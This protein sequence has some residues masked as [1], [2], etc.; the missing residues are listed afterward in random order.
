MDS[1]FNGRMAAFRWLKAQDAA[2]RTIIPGR[3]LARGFEFEG[4]RIT[5]KGQ[6]GIWFPQGWEM[7]VSITTRKDGPYP[8]DS[9]SPDGV[10]TYA[11]RG[12]D[13][14]HH[15]NR[16]LRRACETRTPLIYFTEIRDSL[17][18]AVWPMIIVNDDPN[19]RCV[20]AMIEPAY[21]GLKPAARLD[22]D[23]LSP[24]DVRRY[25]TVQARQR[26]HQTAFRDLV[27]HAYD[28]HCAI[29]RLHHPELLDAAHITPDSESEGLPIVN[30]G[31]SLCKIHHAA[32][33]QQFI[34]IDPDYRV[35]VRR[36]LLEEKDGPMLRHGLQELEGGMLFLPARRRDVPDPDRLDERFRLFLSA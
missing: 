34:G 11:Y 1:E 10:L 5:L 31:L 17:Y 9:I 21:S 25:V 3:E 32:Y 16:G 36:D 8:A 20:T 4:R 27:I 30:N 7:P 33:D 19:R 15:D 26:L 6:T 29:C 24:L 35:H 28:E 2:G 22:D 14:G 23:H 18:E 12:M 13:P